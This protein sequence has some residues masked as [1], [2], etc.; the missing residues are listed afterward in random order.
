[1][2]RVAA[3]YRT[4]SIILDPDKILVSTMLDSKPNLHC[5]D[6]VSL[7]MLC[8]ILKMKMEKS[9]MEVREVI[10]RNTEVIRCGLKLHSGKKIEYTTSNELIG[11]L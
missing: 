11:S 3:R 4:V 10:L 2:P 1:M 9:N 5:S 7:M 6:I 8:I